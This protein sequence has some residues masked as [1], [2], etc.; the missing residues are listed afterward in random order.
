MLANG[1]YIL[2]WIELHDR[3]LRYFAV[4]LPLT[5]RYLGYFKT[6]PREG[7]L[8]ILGAGD[9]PLGG[10]PIFTI[11]CNKDRIDCHYFGI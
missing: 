8:Y 5:F 10:V 6:T 1:C 4:M 7:I 3:T 9:V 2:P 11:F